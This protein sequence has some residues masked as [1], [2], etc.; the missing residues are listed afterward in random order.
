MSENNKV[1]LRYGIE[2]PKQRILDYM[3]K[4]PGKFYKILPIYEGRDYKTK[5]I[6]ISQDKAYEA[7]QKY[8][9]TF[10][11]EVGGFYYLYPEDETIF[12]LLSLLE[13]MN[14]I[15][16]DKHKELK[17]VVLKCIDKSKKMLENIK[18]E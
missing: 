10:T 8:I 14:R 17:T 7:Y 13:S 4:L 18:E 12:E 1:I 11:L 16:K 2:I 9:Q 15:E 3:E 6:T 5:Q